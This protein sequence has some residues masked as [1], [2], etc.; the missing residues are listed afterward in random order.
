[1]RKLFIVL[2]AVVLAASIA[3][4]NQPTTTG[5]PSST[6][7]SSDAQTGKMLTTDSGLEIPEILLEDKEISIY[8]IGEPLDLLPEG[9]IYENVKKFYGAELALTSLTV[10]NIFTTLSTAILSGDVPDLVAGHGGFPDVAINELI[11]PVDGLVDYSMDVMKH[12]KG[13]YDTYQLEGKHWMLPMDDI[14]TS[15]V[16][17]NSTIFE[18]NDLTTPRVL[19]ENDQWTWDKLSE[20]AKALTLDTNKDGTPERWGLGMVGW[21]RGRLVLTTGENLIKIDGSDITSNLSSP[22]VERTFNFL[23]DMVFKD[24]SASPNGDMFYVH[25]G[26]DT[27]EIAMVMSADFLALRPRFFPNLKLADSLEFVR[28]RRILRPRLIRQPDTPTDSSCRRAAPI[29]MAQWRS[30]MAV[31][32]RSTSDTSRDR[33]CT[34]PSWTRTWPPSRDSSPRPMRSMSSGTPNTGR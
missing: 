23:F 19:F 5:T 4:C 32:R 28:I 10:E 22:N 12:L 34:S 7:A 9:A 27:G 14:H 33:P 15:A 20:Y 21:H 11:D 16:F 17:Y 24:K 25:T 8:V 3:S 30:S 26:M 29:P 6:P 31:P 13:A 1:M 2:L 18:D